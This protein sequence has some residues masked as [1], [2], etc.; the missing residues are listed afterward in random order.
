MVERL[1]LLYICRA[2]DSA[3]AMLSLSSN[4]CMIWTKSS[5]T[6]EMAVNISATRTGERQW[7]KAARRQA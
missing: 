3:E 5:P 1:A 6:V 2:C 4:S 7:A